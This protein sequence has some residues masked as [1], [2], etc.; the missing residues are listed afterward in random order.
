MHLQ[1][2]KFYKEKIEAHERREKQVDMQFHSIKS[3]LETKLKE[4]TSRFEE[5][6]K[7]LNQ[8]LGEKSDKLFE[9]SSQVKRLQEEYKVQEDNFDLKER[10][11]RS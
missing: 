6:I 9:T 2:E 4:T 3:D 1:Q 7:C 8:E 5:K 10:R 11:L